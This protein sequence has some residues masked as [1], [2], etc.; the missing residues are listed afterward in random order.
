MGHLPLIR[1]SCKRDIA[2][3][4]RLDERRSPTDANFI[5]VNGVA[6]NWVR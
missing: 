1:N 5:L 4:E 6:M 2:I 3:G